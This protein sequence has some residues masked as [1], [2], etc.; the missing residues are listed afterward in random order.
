MTRFLAGPVSLLLALF[1][2]TGILAQTSPLAVESFQGLTTPLPTPPPITESVADLGNTKLGYWDTGGA[3]PV[4]ILLHPGSGSGESYPYQLAAFAKAGYRVISYSRRGHF[5]SE[6]GSELDTFFAADDLLH[7]M[8]HLKVEKAHLV[9]NAL[10]GYVALD[11][12]ISHPDRVSSLVIACSMMGISEPAFT[13]TLQSL[14]PA[15][16]Q[17]LP[18]EV[19]ELGASYRAANPAGVAEWK[20][21][22]ERAGSGSPVRMKNEIDWP[23]LAKIKPSVLLVTGDADLWMPPFLLRQVGDKMPGSTVAIIPHAGHAVQ[24][25]QPEIFNR[26]VLEFLRAKA[27]R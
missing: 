24:W 13:R 17:Q 12:A 8:N 7:L 4:V 23:K 25:E 2:A 5:R 9:G 6:K 10:G 19:K 27:V 15:P 14:R 21:R 26:T 18:M 1:F 11:F 20:R 3:G 22:H 16:F